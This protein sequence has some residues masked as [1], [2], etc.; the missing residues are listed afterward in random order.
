ML[1]AA[2]ESA[3]LAALAQAPPQP[4]LPPQLPLARIPC[5]CH[6]TDRCYTNAHEWLAFRKDSMKIGVLYDT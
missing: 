1:A 5:F 4:P 3:P 6:S 2:A